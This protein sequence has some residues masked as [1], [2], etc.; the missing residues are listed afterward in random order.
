MASIG[1]A[2][3]LLVAEAKNARE[4]GY[5]ER[6]V[7]LADLTMTNFSDDDC[8]KA[9]ERANRKVD[10]KTRITYISARKLFKLRL[11]Y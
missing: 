11:T 5:R 8:K 10:S 9:A 4:F 1:R 3:N 6:L 7:P 2:T